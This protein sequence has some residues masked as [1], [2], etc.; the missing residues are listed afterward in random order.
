MMSVQFF[1]YLNIAMRSN[2]CDVLKMNHKPLLEADSSFFYNNN[3]G[4]KCADPG[5]T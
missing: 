2:L 1:W 4:V 3:N 5:A